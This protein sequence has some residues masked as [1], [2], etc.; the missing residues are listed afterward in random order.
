MARQNLNAN[1]AF[2]A[3]L[4]TPGVG[5]SF[6]ESRAAAG[7]AASIS[8]TAPVNYPS[9]WLRLKRSVNTFS[10]SA[11][12]DGINWVQ[13][14]SLSITMTD[15]VYVGVV[16]SSHTN[17]TAA[18]AQFR[19]YGTALGATA[20]NA[21]TSPV[22]PPGPSSRKTGL[23]ITEIM[24]KPAPRTDGRNLE[25]IEIYNSNPYFEDISGYH[26]S[27]DINY[28]FP[29]N[30]ILRRGAYLVIAKIPGDIQAIYAVSAVAGPYSRSLNASG[31]VQLLSDEPHSNKFRIPDGT[32][33]PARG[34]ISFTEDQLGFSLSAKGETIYLVDSTLKRVIDAVAFEAQSKGISF[35]RFPDGASAFYRL[36]TITQGAQN[37]AILIDDI[38]INELM[39]S[40]ISEDTNDEYIEI[41]NK[42]T[43]FVDLGGW[44]FTAG[45]TFTFPSNTV[46]AADAYLVIAKSQ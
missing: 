2:A 38:V 3:P 17:A 34:F 31:T 18:V 13:L 40:P 42:G 22:E 36:K 20:V 39:Y 28:T 6:F 44:Q 11:S 5:G 14:G 45:V 26:I 27:G 21:L 25:F 12:F 8:G 37:S 33:I 1:S 23:A 9:T 24:Y 4:T 7:A 29:A 30:T 41:Y 19:D 35:G 46:L 32:S 16:V 10:G 15:P 43:N